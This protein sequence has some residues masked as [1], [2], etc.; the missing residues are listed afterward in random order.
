VW[1]WHWLDDIFDLLHDSGIAIDL[2][3]GTASRRPG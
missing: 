2:G 3:T 1:R